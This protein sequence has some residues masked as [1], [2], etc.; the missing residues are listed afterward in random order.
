MVYSEF[1]L[2]KALRDFDLTLEQETALFRDVQEVSISERLRSLLDD[3]IPLALTINTVALTINTEMSRSAMIMTPILVELRNLMNKQISLFIG[4]EFK[5]APEQ[6]LNGYCD[7]IISQS[8][9]QLFLQAPVLMM[10]EA[11]KEDI[12]A[13]IGQCVAEMVAAR[14]HNKRENHDS[15]TIYGVVTAG[16]VWKFLCLQG[17]VVIVDKDEYYLTNSARSWAF[18]CTLQAAR[19][20]RT[21]ESSKWN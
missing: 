1:T 5:V 13:G 14:I 21:K 6:G 20:R 8:P 19:N 4:I 18:C 17:G 3:Y 16:N 11:K 10:V 15:T 7:Y 12:T 9:M 2:D